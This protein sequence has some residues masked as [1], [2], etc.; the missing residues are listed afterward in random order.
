MWN[1]SQHESKKS[2]SDSVPK[3]QVETFLEKISGIQ[4]M[5]Q[6][7]LSQK[8]IFLSLF[9]YY[10]FLGVGN[11]A[12]KTFNYLNLYLYIHIQVMAAEHC[13]ARIRWWHQLMTSWKL[14]STPRYTVQSF[15]LDCDWYRS[16]TEVY[17]RSMYRVSVEN[18]ITIL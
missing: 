11:K 10:F 8:Y 6:K 7:N 14:P 17:K 9:L 18:N 3:N 5:R 16:L 4:K 13:Q 2:K 12:Q 15:R 1:Q